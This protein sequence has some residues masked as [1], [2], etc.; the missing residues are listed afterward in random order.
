MPDDLERVTNHIAGLR[1]R[2]KRVEWPVGTK[3]TLEGRPYFFDDCWDLDPESTGGDMDDATPVVSLS[4]VIE[5]LTYRRGACIS[6]PLRDPNGKKL[7][8]TVEVLE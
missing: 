1:S 7:R 3:V 2:S 4:A 6:S 8:I 5:T